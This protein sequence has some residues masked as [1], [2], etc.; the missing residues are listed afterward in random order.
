MIIILDCLFSG[1]ITFILA[2]IILEN[3][4]EKKYKKNQLVKKPLM[5]YISFFLIGIIFQIISSYFL[6]N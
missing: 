3:I 2:K 4:I 1:I 5:L 6:I